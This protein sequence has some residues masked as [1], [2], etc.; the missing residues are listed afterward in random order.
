MLCG[1]CGPRFGAFAAVGVRER[2]TLSFLALPLP[3]CQRLMP[4]RGGAAAVNLP[5][6][7]VG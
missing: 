7:C 3:V 2:E 4:L 1:A 5:R 6:T